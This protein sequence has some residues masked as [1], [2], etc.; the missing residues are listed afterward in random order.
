MALSLFIQSPII[1]FI[2]ILSIL[3]AL[4]VHEYGHAFAAYVLG[5]PTA[6][7]MGRLTLN[8]LAHIDLFGFL[9]FLLVGFGWGKP[10]PFNPFNLR[11]KKYGPAIVALAGPLFN[12]FSIIIFGL[13]FVL[14]KNYFF[15]NSLLILFLSWLVIIN[16][17]LM[18]FNLIPIPPLD[19][20]KILYAV[21]PKNRE[22][23]VYKMERN[24]PF[25]LLGLLVLDRLM[26]ISIFGSLFGLVISLISRIFGI[27]FY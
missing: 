6:K 5:D 22:D 19:G 20:S 1:F 3:F 11:N 23:I 27:N 16:A 25:I 24:G 8:P 4:S 13:I 26:P 9:F 12:L 7:N 17:V 2:F 15:S 10:V 18:V 21:L 14:V